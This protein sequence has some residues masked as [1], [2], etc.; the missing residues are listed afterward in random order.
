[1]PL[2]HALR[3][4]VGC[5]SCCPHRPDTSPTERTGHQAWAAYEPTVRDGTYWGGQVGRGYLLYVTTGRILQILV[6]RTHDS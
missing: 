5:F 2:C 1:M 6:H 4:Q 3:G